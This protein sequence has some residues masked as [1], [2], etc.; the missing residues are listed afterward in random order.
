MIKTLKEFLEF[1]PNS[2]ESY[3]REEIKENFSEAKNIS[4][5]ISMLVQLSFF[6]VAI[7]YFVAKLFRADDSFFSLTSFAA[8][9]LIM[10]CLSAA[11]L[12]KIAT[13][14]VGFFLQ[15]SVNHER[16]WIK[17][18]ILIFA[19]I[20]AALFMN[21]IMFLIDDLAETHSLERVIKEYK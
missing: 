11:L 19:F 7:K 6:S 17:Y 16:R 8:C 13:I 2:D 18:A 10:S 21:G 15:D 20:H 4:D 14:V 5:F 1:Y 12:Y 9:L 3:W